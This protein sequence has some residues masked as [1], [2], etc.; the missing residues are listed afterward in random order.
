MLLFFA[1][2][3]T[4]R[5]PPGRTPARSP[6]AAPSPSAPSSLS[7]WCRCRRAWSDTCPRAPAGRGGFAQGP[8]GHGRVV[9]LREL[10]FVRQSPVFRPQRAGR[11]RPPDLRRDPVVGAGRVRDCADR[12]LGGVVLHEAEDRG[13]LPV[14][15]G[16]GGEDR[17]PGRG[18][19]RERNLLS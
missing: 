16:R 7:G 5:A 1:P 17:L 18:G 6:P 13:A 3:R 4:A 8:A 15:G 9:L 14:A 11:R 19:Q 12:V 2:R 10:P